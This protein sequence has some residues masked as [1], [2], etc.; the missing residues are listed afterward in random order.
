MPL[1][2]DTEEQSGASVV[3]LEGELTETGGQALVNTVK[4]LLEKDG[5]C[6]VLDMGGVPFV[7]S[8]GLAELVRI[9]AQANSQG[10]R[11]VL[12]NLTPFVSDILSTTKLNQFFDICTDVDAAL[13][14]LS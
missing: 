2:I 11:A 5:G 7:S 3:R 1:R 4:R 10:G 6:V 14:Q 13:A 12:A 9:T 8:S